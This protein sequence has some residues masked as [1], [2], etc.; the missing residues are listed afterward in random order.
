[1]RVL[2][3]VCGVLTAALGI[4]F[5]VFL[6]LDEFNPLMNFVDCAASRWMLAVLCLSGVLTGILSGADKPA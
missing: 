3:N 6:V 5:L 1:M 4:V 2:R